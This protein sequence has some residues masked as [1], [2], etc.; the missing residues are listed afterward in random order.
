MLSPQRISNPDP[1]TFIDDNLDISQTILQLSS[2]RSGSTLL[3]N[4]IN[5][6]NTLRMMFEP[7]YYEIPGI[8]HYAHMYY[9]P[10]EMP[11]PMMMDFV[12]FL[13]GAGRHPWSDRFVL[14][15]RYTQRIFKEVRANLLA[16]WLKTHFPACKLVFLIRHPFAVCAS[17]MNVQFFLATL[18]SLRIEKDFPN[19]AALT[20]SIGE[21]AWE[22]YV[23]DWC[24]ENYIPLK[25]LHR[26]DYHLVFFENMFLAPQETMSSLFT[27]LNRSYDEA[28]I[29]KA[30]R[31]PSQTF[32]L[33]DPGFDKNP[34]QQKTYLPEYWQNQLTSTQIARGMEILS[35]FGLDKLYQE[36]GRPHPDWALHLL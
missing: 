33:I 22:Q 3:A 35:W 9:S 11:V 31:L 27:F 13:S 21:D 25:M 18:N 23:F 19:L 32:T 7:M 16:P 2:G 34:E 30:L 20:T 24:I 26:D 14:P 36:N 8:S 10:S 1:V 17:K 29:F 6:D 4:V 28:Q 12:P 5:Y 15:H